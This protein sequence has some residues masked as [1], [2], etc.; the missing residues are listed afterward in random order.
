MNWIIATD[1]SCI[2]NPGP[3]AFAVVAQRPDGSHSIR[4]LPFPDTTVGEMEVRGL[5]EALLWCVDDVLW[6]HGRVEIRCD[7]Q[8]VVNGYNDWLAGWEAKGFHKKGGLAHAD[9]WREIASCKARLGDNVKVVWVRAHQANGC[10]LNAK[11]DNAAYAAANLQKREGHCLQ[12]TLEGVATRT[13]TPRQQAPIRFGPT[14][15]PE[16]KPL[17]P[18][19]DELV[20]ALREARD[21]IDDLRTPADTGADQLSTKIGL[22]VERAA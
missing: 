6:S 11:A 18:T 2:G 20:S 9:L 12:A 7:S 1:G 5:L 14:P 21:T 3:G 10:P 4:A 8:Y 22:L 16:A 15:E 19:Y 17:R 13:N